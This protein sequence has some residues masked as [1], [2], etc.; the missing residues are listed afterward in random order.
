MDKNTVE[1]RKCCGIMKITLLLIGKT[2]DK[3]IEQ[4]IDDYRNRLS[5]Y[6]SFDIKILPELKNTR[7]KT[8]EQQKEEEGKLILQA[9]DNT[10]TL[11]LLD[12]RGKEMRSIEFASYL[13]RLMTQGKNLVFAVGGPYGFC[14]DVYERA[15]SML[16]MSKMT[17]SHQMIRMF[18]TE[19]LYRAMTILR[20]EPYHHE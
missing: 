14:K 10:A 6:M 18:F 5:H 2:T 13:Q 11:I 1:R 15:D 9:V 17:L 19:Q 4:I 20:N 8:F 3:R 12:E 7:N 16:S